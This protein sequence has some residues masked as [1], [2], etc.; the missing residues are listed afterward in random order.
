MVK[1]YK[2]NILLNVFKSHV[3]DIISKHVAS[4][5]SSNRKINFTLKPEELNLWAKYKAYKW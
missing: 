5:M 1:K 3:L 4:K 2:L